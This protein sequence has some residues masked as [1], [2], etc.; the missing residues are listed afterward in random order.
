MS[1]SFHLQ[2]FSPILWVVFL[3]CLGFLLLCRNFYGYQRFSNFPATAYLGKGRFAEVKCQ[4]GA[5]DKLR[6]PFFYPSSTCRVRALTLMEQG[7]KFG[8]NFSHLSSFIV[9]RFLNEAS[10]SEVTTSIHHLP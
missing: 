1:Q 6:T 10:K 2:I 5:A 4:S 7:K 8:S 3:L 9:Q